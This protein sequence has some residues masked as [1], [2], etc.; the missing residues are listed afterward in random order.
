VKDEI[1]KDITTL[2]TVSIYKKY[3]L[4]QDVW[5]FKNKAPETYHKTYD[6]FKHYVA[7]ESSPQTLVC[8]IILFKLLLM[9]SC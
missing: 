4:G 5:Y 1:I 9:L 8:K 6:E 3:L 7:D 2:D